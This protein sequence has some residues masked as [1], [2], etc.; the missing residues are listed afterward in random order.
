[1]LWWSETRS[2]RSRGR[3][4]DVDAEMSR[5]LRLFLIV[6]AGLTVLAAGFLWA[7]PQ[8]CRRVAL[9]R[10]P[11]A[12]GRAVAIEDV[13]LNLF[14]GRLAIKGFR[15]ADRDGPE[16]FVAFERL[17]V[18]LSLPALLRSHVDLA[19]I[20]LTT[21]SV[22]VVRKGPAEVD[23]SDLLGARDEPVATPAT[24]RRWAVTVRRLKIARGRVEV[25]DGAVTPPAEWLVQD[26]DVDASNVTT[27]SVD[28]PGQLALRVRVNETTLSLDA[29]GVRMAPLQF[30][31]KL[32]VDGFHPRRLIPYVYEPMGTQHRP[33]EGSLAL[34]LAAEVD[35]DAE[36]VRKASLSGTVRLDGAALIRVGGQDPFL[37]ASRLAVE[38]KEVDLI[39]RTL[40]IGSVTIEGLDAK[41]RRDARGD[42]DVV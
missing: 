27:R 33:T 13:D 40:T 29:E 22:R 28:P 42:I 4:R 15:L 10:I 26:L 2:R 38:V 19:E 39:A 24:S 36:E 32:A 37:S 5:A 31:A 14:S 21:P 18:R 1:M 17:D 34:A 16:S 8:I 30:R 11:K 41:V 6:G 25:A 12:T 9:D 23:F 20:A 7:L 35:S 3:T